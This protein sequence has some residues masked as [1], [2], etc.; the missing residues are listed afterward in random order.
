AV[1]NSPTIFFDTITHSISEKMLGYLPYL[2]EGKFHI[3]STMNQAIECENGI[4][5]NDHINQYQGRQK[6]K[7][8]IPTS[9]PSHAQTSYNSIV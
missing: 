7:S 8:N 2:I 5:L 4:I 3:N 1:D 6:F 9:I